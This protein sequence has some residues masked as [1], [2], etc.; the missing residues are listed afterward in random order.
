[1]HSMPDKLFNAP[2]ADDD[3]TPVADAAPLDETAADESPKQEATVVVTINPD[4]PLA[5]D[6][7][8]SISV[9]GFNDIELSGSGTVKVTPA[10]ADS[11]VTT[12]FVV[13][14]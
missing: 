3:V 6:G 13:I 8:H 10:H 7:K 1:M 2:G 5:D 12:N 4:G 14:K 9:P 11:L